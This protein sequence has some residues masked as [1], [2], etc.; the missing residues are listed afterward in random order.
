MGVV[1]LSRVGSYFRRPSLFDYLGSNPRPLSDVTSPFDALPSLEEE[2]AERE[3]RRP[4]ISSW[5]A[6]LAA[7]RL[8]ARDG[9]DERRLGAR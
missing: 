1:F 3:R 5:D 2:L 7:W 6:R 4:T 9:R 8:I